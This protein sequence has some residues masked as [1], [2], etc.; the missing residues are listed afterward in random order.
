[1]SADLCAR[2]GKIYQIP[3]HLFTNI[4]GYHAFENHAA[5][6][7]AGTPATWVETAHAVFPNSRSM[8]REERA[9]FDAHAYGD[10]APLSD[11]EEPATWNRKDL[12][13]DQYPIGTLARDHS[14]S[15]WRRKS[16]GWKAIPFGDTFPTP[17]A[18]ACEVLLPPVPLSDSGTEPTKPHSCHCAVVRDCPIMVHPDAG[19]QASLAQISEEVARYD[20]ATGSRSEVSVVSHRP[21]GGCFTSITKNAACDGAE[22]P[23]APPTDCAECKTQLVVTPSGERYC[24]VAKCRLAGKTVW[25][26]PAGAATA[27]DWRNDPRPMLAL[28]IVLAGMGHHDMAGYLTFHHF[29]LSTE[30]AAHEEARREVERLTKALGVFCTEN[31]RPTGAKADRVDYV[32]IGSSASLLALHNAWGGE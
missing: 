7:E 17:A 29:E 15:E 13:W 32:V 18:S 4:P 21:D 22:T 2:C 24:M 30:R 23:P 11:S 5:V 6:P 31:P 16:G 12:A 10:I 1:M 26:E 14:G 28:S 9:E 19:V 8:T 25:P 27:F 3:A 20:D